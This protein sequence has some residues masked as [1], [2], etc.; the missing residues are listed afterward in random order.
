MGSYNDEK[1][2]TRAFRPEESGIF[3]A[4]FS[5]RRVFQEK[6]YRLTNEYGEVR[7]E[8]WRNGKSEKGI[9]FEFTCSMSQ[10]GV[11]FTQECLT[12][13]LV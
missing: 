10:Y 9:V 7:G 3:S 6:S 13:A 12:Y 11:G 5:L 1:S 2:Q 4:D 8:K